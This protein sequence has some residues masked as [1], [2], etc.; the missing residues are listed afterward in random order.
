VFNSFSLHFTFSTFI[1]FQFLLQNMLPINLWLWLCLELL[2]W[3]LLI[4]HEGYLVSTISQ[5]PLYLYDPD[6]TDVHVF[7]VLSFVISSCLLL[8]G[9]CSSSSWKRLR[10]VVSSPM[11][12]LLLLLLL[13]LFAINH[14]HTSIHYCVVS[15]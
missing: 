8:S 10:G 4:L 5:T 7:C 13:L 3:I 12:L 9:V 15:T 6:L 14:C 11:L 2:S 1:I